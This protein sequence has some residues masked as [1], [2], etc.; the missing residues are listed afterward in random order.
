MSGNGGTEPK[1]PERVLDV[2][3]P[4]KCEVCGL[5]TDK[6]IKNHPDKKWIRVDMFPGLALFACPQCNTASFN[7]NLQ[8]NNMRL[9]RW[10]KED[11]EQR[12]KPATAIIDPKTNKAINLKR[13]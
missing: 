5:E 6:W 1:R 9:N 7:P 13:V 11:Q 2:L 3:S 10:Q 4:D 8:A 12:I